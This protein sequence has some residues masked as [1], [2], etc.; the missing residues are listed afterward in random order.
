[1]PT[2]RRSRLRSAAG[3]V[4]DTAGR[5]LTRAS[6]EQFRQAEDRMAALEKTV[7]DLQ[8]GDTDEP[9]GDLLAAGAAVHGRPALGHGLDL[10]ATVARVKAALVTPPPQAE[11]LATDL[12]PLLYPSRD[13]VVTPWVRHHGSWEP[14][15]CDVIRDLLPV[16]GTFV[17]VGAHVGYV[18]IAAARAVGA[19]G[20]G[21]A[22]EPA[23]ENFALLAANLVSSGIDWVTTIHAAAGATSGMI[24]LSLSEENS[25]DHR[26]VA[27]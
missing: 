8:E 14:E 22:V 11:R 19:T 20:H 23:P 17:D 13:E 9:L 24:E 25:G 1:M 16:G 3:R 6:D 27:L 15:T 7:A 4:V 12:G 10:D 2:P 5:R 18:S 26:A 21:I